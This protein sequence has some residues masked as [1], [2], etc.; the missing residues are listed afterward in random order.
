MENQSWLESR[1]VWSWTQWPLWV[2]SNLKYSMTVSL[3]IF[4]LLFF[5]TTY[6]STSYR[7]FRSK[8][9]LC[10]NHSSTLFTLSTLPCTSLVRLYH[11]ETK[12]K[13]ACSTQVF[14][15]ARTPSTVLIANSQPAT[16]DVKLGLFFQSA[17][18][19]ISLYW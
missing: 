13:T 10:T 3:F 11:L 16:A 2:P 15:T 7:F 6:S 12:F 17:S 19:G 9:F 8:I 18:L 4:F 5:H 1:G 14:R